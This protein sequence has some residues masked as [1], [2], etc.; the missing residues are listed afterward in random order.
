MRTV[1][2]PLR[3]DDGEARLLISSN[4][5]LR[6]SGH[7]VDSR[8]QIFNPVSRAYIDIGAGVPVDIADQEAGAEAFPGRDGSAI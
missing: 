4:E 8:V 6:G 2:F 1:A 5:E 3:A 7:P